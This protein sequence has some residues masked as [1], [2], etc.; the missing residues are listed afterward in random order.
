MLSAMT[1]KNKFTLLSVITVL[2]FALSSVIG[3]YQV[4]Q[5]VDSI[6]HDLN[7]NKIDSEIMANV[8]NARNSFKTQVQEWKDI[9][10][11][12]N[13]PKMYDKYWVQFGVEEKKTQDALLHAIELAR[14]EGLSSAE[15]ESLLKIH[16][17]LGTKYR[18]ALAT[19]NQKDPGTGKLV[20]AQVKGMD[21]PMAAG[22][23]K[24]ANDAT[25]RYSASV[26]AQLM[27]TDVAYES[28]RT[29]LIVITLLGI[30]ASAG[31]SLWI[32]RGLLHRLG[33]EPEYAVG[34]ARTIAVGNLNVQI[35]TLGDDQNSL[36][37]AMKSM[38][39]NLADMIRKVNHN[40]QKLEH[41][42]TR[43]TQTAGIVA[44]N[45]F[46]QQNA[47]HSMAAAVE[48]MSSTVVE[49]TSTMEELS[50]SSTQIAD[51]SKS[52]V[53]IANNTWEYSKKGSDEM[54]RVLALMDNIRA[55]NQN[56]LKEIVELGTRS[57]EI[58]KVM[59]IINAITNQ[60]KL[61]A[62]NA[63][64]EAASA[65][66]YGHRF[67]VVA[68][69]IRRLADNVTDSTGEIETKISQ[70]QDSISR[71]VITSEKGTSTIDLSVEA[72]SNTARNLD[73]LVDAA[74]HT[75]DAAQQISLSTQQQKTASSQVVMA[76]REIVTASSRT[77]Q[78]VR[79]ITEI[80]N[81]MNDMSHELSA[82][83]QQ[84]KLADA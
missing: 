64:L 5:M 84:F 56:S 3:I 66:E 55:D 19:F 11:R 69:E 81:E 42:A 25:Q 9:L 31:I 80:G 83:V 37:A 76:L 7:A 49:I 23:D 78:S 43:L 30:I 28:V 70:I 26:A 41:A 27:R 77:A 74:S 6:R 44:A 51:H 65:G 21:R 72:S 50:A 48:E 67:G 54:R 18:A 57:K 17:E 59:E 16:Q 20:D 24:I 60:T 73:E 38:Q 39:N 45:N 40:V 53:D 13:D 52:V 58:G 32:L 46:S 82:L 1:V 34:I 8:R 33:G 63:A 68:A 36:L 75:R 15:L 62:F 2:L 35:H 79:S 22:M 12:G 71:L 14:A 4:S 47:S 10:I 61:I 29:L